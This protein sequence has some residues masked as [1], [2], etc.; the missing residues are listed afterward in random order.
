MSELFARMNAWRPFTALVVGDFIL[1]EMVYG[2]A[3]RL[4]PDAPVPVLLVKRREVMPGGAANV[5]M[6]LAALRGR[7]I[8]FGVVGADSTARHMRESLAKSSIDASGL[9]E[10]A[11][12]PTTLK[13]NLI[14][15]AQ[16]RHP[17]KMFRLDEESR[18]PICEATQSKLFAAFE[19]QLASADVVIIE[20]YAK[21]VCTPELCQR[22][23]AASRRAG[24]PVF[25]DP[26][27]GVDPLRYKGATTITP[28]RTEAE[29]A[30]GVP[31]SKDNDAVHNAALAKKLLDLLELECVV[32]TLDKHGALLLGREG[33]RESAPMSIPTQAREVYD[34]SG[35]G[36]MFLAGLAAARANGCVWDDSVRF[37]NAAAG[38]EV[39]VFGVQPIP[40][41]NVRDSLLRIAGKAKPGK[42]RTLDEL[43]AEV[44]DLKRRKKRVVFTNGC[45]DVLHSG[46]VTL[47]EKAAAFGDFLVVGL[48]SDDSV[49]RLKGP[50]RPINNEQDRARVLGALESVG[51]VAVFTQ[52]TPLE[53]IKAVRPDTLV[54]G[55]DYTK[56]KVV[57]ADVVESYGGRVELVDLVAGKS[58]TATLAR[59]T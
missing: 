8:A 46:H 26:A 25:V 51:A 41:E 54:K 56:D 13:Q 15:L 32:L 50:T 2:D 4:S 12:R 22:I 14:G 45:F 38:L 49:R 23:I 28:N 43:C 55:A 6:D 27:R 5:C 9:I 58:T 10:D 53:L 3:E 7:V 17:Q 31:T 19:K 30:A 59:M 29:L 21:G 52:D 42:L 33:S 16:S 18:E 39:E 34:V 37:A 1:D 48:N 20:D 57:G 47:L 44:A 40:F 11:A 36:D 35:A 24:K